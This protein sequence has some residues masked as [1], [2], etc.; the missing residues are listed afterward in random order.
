MPITKLGDIT[1]ADIKAYFGIATA[2]TAKDAKIDLV[3]PMV[4]ANIIDFCRHDFESKARTGES[5]VIED[6]TMFI[7]TKNRPVASVQSVIED[8]I[9][10]TENS[11]YYVVKDTG[12]IEKIRDNSSVFSGGYFGYWN[13]GPGKIVLNYTGGEALTQDV[14]LVAYEWVGIWAQLKT[15]AYV[16]DQG[17][18]AA[19]QIN[20]LP[21]SLKQILLNHKHTR[22]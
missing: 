6:N 7:F 22:C 9:T 19:L 4:V 10:L 12:R 13:S 15:T 2:D 14:L 18:E 1:K 3:L 5:P 16:N 21:D 8:G 17:V 20:E 11:D